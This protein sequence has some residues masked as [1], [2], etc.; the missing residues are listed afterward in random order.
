MTTR[1]DTTTREEKPRRGARRALGLPGLLLLGTIGVLGLLPACGHGY[2]YDPYYPYPG[3]YYEDCVCDIFGC[4][5]TVIY[6]KDEA[7][8]DAPAPAEVW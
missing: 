5:C 6:Y 8:P 3:P 7:A 4:D 2:Y 1:T